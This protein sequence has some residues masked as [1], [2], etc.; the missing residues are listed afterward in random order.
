MIN[1][2]NSPFIWALLMAGIWSLTQLVDPLRGSG[3]SKSK[4]VGNRVSLVEE[5]AIAAVKVNESVLFVDDSVHVLTSVTSI[6]WAKQSSICVW[7]HGGLS[8]SVFVSTSSLFS[9]AS[10]SFGNCCCLGVNTLSSLDTDDGFRASDQEAS[11][12]DGLEE[13]LPRSSSPPPPLSVS[14]RVWNR[15]QNPNY[16]NKILFKE[17]T[18]GFKHNHWF[19]FTQTL[20][21]IPLLNFTTPHWLIHQLKW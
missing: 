4:L 6:A 14:L 18:V 12:I 8:Q 15:K 1:I 20:S 13:Q 2:Y 11:L 19:D 10:N 21:T 16:L 17:I 5:P 3:N 7:K 9:F